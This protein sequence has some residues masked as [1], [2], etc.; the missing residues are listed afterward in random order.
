M[1]DP[2][3]HFK[4]LKMRMFSFWQNETG[5]KSSH[6]DDAM[7][8]TVIFFVTYISGAKLKEHCL[9]VSRDIL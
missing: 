2:L 7:G 5:A 1:Q 8:V 3:S 9:S 4:G 6:G